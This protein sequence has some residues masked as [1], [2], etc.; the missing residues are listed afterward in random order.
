MLEYTVQ[1]TLIFLMDTLEG[2]YIDSFKTVKEAKE[3]LELK[4]CSISQAIR[5]RRQCNGFYW[6]RTDAPTPTI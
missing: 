1:K 6:T 4:L 5:L 2:N 3:K